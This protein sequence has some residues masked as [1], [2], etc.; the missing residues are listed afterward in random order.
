MDFTSFTHDARCA[1]QK[2][3]TYGLSCLSP[4]N[5]IHSRRIFQLNLINPDNQI[6]YPSDILV[7]FIMLPKRHQNISYTDPSITVKIN[8]GDNNMSTLKLPYFEK[9]MFDIGDAYL[10]KLQ[11]RP[12]KFTP[13]IYETYFVS[14][15]SQY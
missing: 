6:I 2:S 7:G 11:L 9:A 1:I 12:F 8:L 10:N 5:K 3:E 13:A 15:A 4:D 14:V